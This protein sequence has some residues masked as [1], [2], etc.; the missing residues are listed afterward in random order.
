M[1]V[2]PRIPATERESI[3]AGFRALASY[4]A[5]DNPCTGFLQSGFRSDLITIATPMTRVTRPIHTH[6]MLVV[7]KLCGQSEKAPLPSVVRPTKKVSDFLS[8]PR[9]D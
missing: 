8:R 6:H 9:G 5:A 7:M 4:A 3:E 1:S 2:P